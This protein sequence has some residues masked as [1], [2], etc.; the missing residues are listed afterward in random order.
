MATGIN[1]FGGFGN[2]TGMNED[3]GNGQGMGGLMNEDETSMAETLKQ[4]RFLWEDNF[5]KM[6]AKAYLKSKQQRELKHAN[7]VRGA[8]H[9]PPYAVMRP[10]GAMT[11]G[12]AGPNS[13]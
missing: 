3:P 12:G 8:G 7:R 5:Q 4:L 13:G 2:F 11:M 6:C 9:V 1:D 10:P